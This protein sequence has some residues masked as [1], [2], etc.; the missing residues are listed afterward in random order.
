MTGQQDQSK[1]SLVVASGNLGKIAEFRELLSDLPLNI[2]PQP[3]DLVVN[4]TG[5]TFHEN[6]RIKALAASSY[7]EEWALADDSGLSVEA[8]D[9]APGIHSARYANTDT[10]RINRL[11]KELELFQ[12]R[13]AIF[14]AALCVAHEGKILL[15]VEGRCEGVITRVPRGKGGFGYDPIFEV[16]GLGITFAEMGIEKKKLFGHR[17]RAFKLL[18]PGLKKLLGV[19]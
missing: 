19:I 11:L 15:E 4:E 14:T 13:D 8:L 9:G 2:I 10:E 5:I 17:G 12:N 16:K 6:A 1:T 18:F 7:T 3:A